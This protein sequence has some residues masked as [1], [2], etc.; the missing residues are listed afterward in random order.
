MAALSISWRVLRITSPKTPHNLTGK[1]CGS[2]W[3]QR[4]AWAMQQIAVRK[5]LIGGQMN[6]DKS[7]CVRVRITCR[8]V[9]GSAPDKIA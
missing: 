6:G 4:G 2:S 3:S 1:T 8:L 7:P 9:L 5:R